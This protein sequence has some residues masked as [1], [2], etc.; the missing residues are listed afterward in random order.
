MS[1]KTYTVEAERSGEWWVVVGRGELDGIFTQA[2]TLDQLERVMLPDAVALIKDVA[3][4]SFDVRVV[5]R[6]PDAI[7]A[8]E[9]EAQRTRDEAEAAR[10]RATRAM[11]GLVRRMLDDGYTLRDVARVLGISYQRV[12][13]IARKPDAA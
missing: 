6:V 5:P 7:H 11:A 3:P 2:R 4:G 8:L 9:V 1:R 10:G 13:Q 12:H